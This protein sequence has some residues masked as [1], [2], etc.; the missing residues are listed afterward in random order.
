MH[1]IALSDISVATVI[2]IIIAILID[3]ATVISTAIT[4]W[5][6]GISTEQLGEMGTDSSKD[7]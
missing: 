1:C 7:E 4:F 2:A 3:F 5:V 6:G